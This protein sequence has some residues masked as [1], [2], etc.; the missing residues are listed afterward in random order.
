MEAVIDTNVILHGRKATDIQRMYTV[1]EVE[2]ELKSSEANRRK[3][4]LDLN[5]QGPGKKDLRKVKEESNEINSPTS[6][7]DEKLVALALT[8]GKTLVTD[9]KAMQNLALRLDVDFSGY[10]EEKITETREWSKIC[11]N[12]G[13]QVSSPPCPRCGHQN[14][15]RKTS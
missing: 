5:I 6:D 3:Q 12:C 8:L 10:M 7:T 1:P 14:L 13:K 9:D 4:N 15:T 2:K 11:V